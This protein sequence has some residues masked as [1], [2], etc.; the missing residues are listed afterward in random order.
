MFEYAF[1][2][3]IDWVPAKNEIADK[4]KNNLFSITQFKKISAD[5]FFK[6]RIEGTLQHREIFNLFRRFSAFK[7]SPSG[8]YEF[9]ETVLKLVE[10]RTK[11]CPLHS[12][13]KL[14]AFLLLAQLHI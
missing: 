11:Q 5:G 2:I 10:I 4:Q 9:Q 12:D 13:K 1:K 3:F 6:K 7:R 8:V 14:D